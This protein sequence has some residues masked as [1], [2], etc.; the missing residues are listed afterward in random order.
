MVKGSFN[1]RANILANEYWT[2]KESAGVVVDEKMRLDEI[3]RL[4]AKGISGKLGFQLEKEASE[5]RTV[6]EEKRTA[7][8]T[9]NAVRRDLLELVSDF[10]PSLDS[11]QGSVFPF[12]SE[13]EPLKEHYFRA[14]TDILF[15]TPKIAIEF[16]SAT[17]SEKGIYVPKADT[18]YVALRVLDYVTMILQEAAK[19]LLRRENAIDRAWKRAKERDYGLM[20]LKIFIENDRPM[21]IE[22]IEKLCKAGDEEYY[23]LVHDDYTKGLLHDL[24]YFASK[25]WE[26]PLVVKKGERYEATDFGRWTWLL[27]KEQ[28]GRETGEGEK[29]SRL[30]GFFRSRKKER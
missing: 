22:E 16:R 18:E 30:S 27:C 10:A 17:I 7:S 1:E 23:K 8:F 15:G 11:R 2:N 3:D 13:R 20:G 4:L 6:I 25:A 29:S 24:E 5:L 9:L 14:I 19:K 28:E 12:D 26:Y 21:S